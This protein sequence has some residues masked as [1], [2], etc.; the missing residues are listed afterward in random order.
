MRVTPHEMRFLK[1]RREGVREMEWP[2]RGSAGNWSCIP[3][4]ECMYSLPLEL[5][6][7][8]KLYM[9]IVDL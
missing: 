3:V 2:N 7:S 8:R 6:N 4:Y 1:A 9:D 5:A